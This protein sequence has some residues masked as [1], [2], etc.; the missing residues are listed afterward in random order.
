MT[1]FI[2]IRPPYK[3][4]PS[5]INNSNTYKKPKYKKSNT[6]LLFIISIIC[7]FIFIFSYANNNSIK[8]AY[9]DHEPIYE[10][11][12]QEILENIAIEK[13]NIGQV[14]NPHTKESYTNNKQD[15]ATDIENTKDPK[16]NNF[17]VD[18]TVLNGARKPGLANEVKEILENNNFS[19]SNIGNSQNKY[20][21]TIIYHTK[22]NQQ[23]AEKIMETI[24]SY[25]PK[26]E[27][28]NQLSNN[29]KILVVIGT[30]L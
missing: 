3:K 23:I 15:K 18:I 11:D 20:S 30:N 19:V 5:K 9:P 4:K 2:D 12:D 21:Q 25:D 17:E 14:D 7:I 16:I 26:L 13:P 29:Q 27:I 22:E 28:N 24:S 10:E 8:Y 1:K 6:G